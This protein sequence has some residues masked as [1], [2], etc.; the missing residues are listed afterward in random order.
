MLK[1]IIKFL[2][3]INKNSHP[4]EIAHAICCGMLLGFM[5]KNNALWYILFIAFLFMRIQKSAFVIFTFLFS[6][7][8]PYL[9]PAFDL[10]G[11]TV[12]K[13]DF[14]QP[15]FVF[16]IKIPLVG[17]TKFY[18]S[19]VM[20][21]LLSSLLLYIPVYFIARLLVQLWRSKLV[22]L[23]RKTRFVKIASKLS[24]VSKIKGGING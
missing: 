8:A 10:I 19:I 4:G 9:D 16:L 11:Y 6:L 1:A 13:M 23:M 18:N 2:K 5:P 7:A 21:S 24:L 3:A 12:L 15:V 17:Y 22:P 20:G 14:L